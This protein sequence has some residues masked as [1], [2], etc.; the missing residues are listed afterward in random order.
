MS[1]HSSHSVLYKNQSKLNYMN[2]LHIYILFCLFKYSIVLYI[3]VICLVMKWAVRFLTKYIW[4]HYLSGCLFVC[5][6]FCKKRVDDNSARY[7]V[8]IEA[9]PVQDIACQL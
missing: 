6:V 8:I 4:T 5:F 7:K 3:F 9:Y 2:V 1:L